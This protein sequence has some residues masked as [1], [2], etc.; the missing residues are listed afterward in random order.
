[1]C[2]VLVLLTCHIAFDIFCDPGSGAGPEIFLVDALD[3]FVLSRM[4]IDGSFM[5]HVH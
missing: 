5:P 4:A 3:G 2:Q 1:M